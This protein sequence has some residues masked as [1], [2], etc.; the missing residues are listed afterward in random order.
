MT[1]HIKKQEKTRIILNVIDKRG[2]SISNK[3]IGKI[4]S[5]DIKEI[6]RIRAARGV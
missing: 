2:A 6:E 4:T 5:F 1:D 3:K